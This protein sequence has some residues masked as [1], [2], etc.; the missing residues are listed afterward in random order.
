MKTDS[1]LKQD[2][3]DE[4]KWE[5]AIDEAGIGVAVN[6]GVVTL[7]GHVTT[8]AEKVIVQQ[9]AERVSG[10]KAVVL[11]IKVKLVGQD[12]RTDEE[13]A[14]TALNNLRWTTDVPKEGILL[15]VEDGW[16]TLEGQVDWNYQKL[17]AESAIKNLRGVLGVVNM[18]QVK[19]KIA[20]SSVKE[21][22]KKTLQRNALLDAEKINVLVEGH[23]I[24]LTGIVRSYAEFKQAGEAAW[25]SP[26]VWLVE[27]KLTIEPRP[28]PA[29]SVVS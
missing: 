5:P 15:K 2:V 16:I 19:S 4:L 12:K 1:Q 8:F 26:G 22:I 11:D 14:K 7:S 18:I 25:S 9:A 29:I 10:V 27:N 24:T 21:N 13:L 28:V 3:L 20:P 23:R 6:D 17:A